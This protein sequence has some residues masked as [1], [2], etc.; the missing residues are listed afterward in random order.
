MNVKKFDSY[1]NPTVDR[2]LSWVTISMIF[3]LLKKVGFSFVCKTVPEIL[4]FFLFIHFSI[5][6]III[7]RK[8]KK[9]LKYF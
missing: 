9:A 5:I 2:I 7:D 6:S 8:K 3:Y 1:R 4:L